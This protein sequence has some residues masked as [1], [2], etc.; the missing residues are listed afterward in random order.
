[1]KSILIS[2]GSGLVGSRLAERLEELGYSVSFLSRSSSPS[3][4]RTVYRWDIQKRELDPKAI[5]NA[6]FIVHLAGAN[7]AQKRWTKK[8]KQEIIDSRV[9]S[10]TLLFQEVKKSGKKLSAF[11]SASAIGYYGAITSEK[12]FTEDDP[13]GSDFMGDVCW[14]WEQSA[15]QFTNLGIRTVKI[16]TGIVLSKKGGALKKMLRPI[17]MGLGS[18]LGSGQQF[19]PWIHID[20]LCGI[21]IRAIEDTTL[22]GAFNA[23]APE[24]VS[25]KEYTRTLARAFKKPLFLPKVPPG[26]LKFM[27][28]EMSS[29]LLNGSRV[30]SDK[31][32]AAGF[33]FHYP[34]LAS[35]LLDLNTNTHE[36]KP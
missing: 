2:G 3:G 14:L 23:V 33:Q 24:P 36:A 18:V 35:A 30:S 15:D 6:D 34:K 1:M 21:Y 25:A 13:S 12:I 20:D 7:I 28:G 9:Q 32:I 17:K 11:I 26:I 8:W 19:M 4:A 22:E 27:L 5:Q 31:I 16:R 10:T 29:I